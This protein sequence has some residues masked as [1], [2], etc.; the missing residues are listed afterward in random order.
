VATIN[1]EL[2]TINSSLITVNSTIMEGNQ[3]IADFNT[4]HTE[5]NRTL[6]EG[7][8]K[9]SSATPESNAERIQSNMSRMND[10]LDRAISNGDMLDARL[11]KV[12]S[13]RVG[14]RK[15]YEIVQS[16]R[17]TVKSNHMKMMKNAI[18]LTQDGALTEAACDMYFQKVFGSSLGQGMAEIWR[19][20]PDDPMAYLG[21]WLL[22]RDEKLNGPHRRHPMSDE[23]ASAKIAAGMHGIHVRREIRKGNKDKFLDQDRQ[24]K[25]E[26]KKHIKGQL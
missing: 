23:Q 3:E 12:V 8:L 19:V 18:T 24:A 5:I 9:P 7:E 13:N 15:N 2:S 22:D 4:K 21:Q 1:S 16:R 14:I 17:L 25:I 26:V 6:L 11:E 10:I 20:K